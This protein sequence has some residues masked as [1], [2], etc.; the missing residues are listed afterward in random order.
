MD[1]DVGFLGI[2]ILIEMAFWIIGFVLLSV[3]VFLLK[4][5][6]NRR[7]RFGVLLLPAISGY[8]Y[9]MRGDTPM[10]LAGMLIAGVPMSVLLPPFV[11]QKSQKDIP[12]FRQFFYCDVIISFVAALMPFFFVFSGI[13]MVPIIFWHTPLSNFI[14][15]VCAVALYSLLAA[16]LY[17]GIAAIKTR[18]E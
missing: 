2:V 1:V 17:Q 3:L 16:F 5:I 12:Q 18:D 10:L 7:I 11:F 9:L 14:V 4:L 6:D 8:T 13:S 15:Y